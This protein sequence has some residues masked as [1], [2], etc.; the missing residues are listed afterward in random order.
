MNR[1]LL[2]AAAALAAISVKP[3]LAQVVVNMDQ[4]TC[5]QF[6]DAPPERQALIASWVGGYF[7]ATKNLNLFELRYAKRNTAVI[8]KYCKKNKKDSFL[9]SFLK[10][11][12]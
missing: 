9:S 10:V 2:I 5:Q 4:I 8:V 6:L 3:A 12:H 1:K 7:S 11:A